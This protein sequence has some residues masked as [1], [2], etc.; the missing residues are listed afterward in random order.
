MIYL[1]YWK[2]PQQSLILLCSYGS[3]GLFTKQLIANHNTFYYFLNVRRN[4]RITQQKKHQNNGVNNIWIDL[5]W[6][7]CYIILQA[8]IPYLCFWLIT[9][10]LFFKLF[11]TL[12]YFSLILAWIAAKFACLHAT[13][14]LNIIFTPGDL[15]K[16]LRES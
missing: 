8:L 7:S 4:Q 15:E 12:W 16:A 10:W 1:K 3:T 9:I 5:I 11:A 13:N 6:G 14:L 2:D